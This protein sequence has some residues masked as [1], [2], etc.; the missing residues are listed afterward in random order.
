MSSHHIVR[1]KQE[2]ALFIRNLGHFDE[3]YLGQ[4]LEWSPTL[5]VS[6]GVYEKVVSLGLKV[7]VVAGP[8]DP[9]HFQENT[10][11]VSGRADELG[12][13]LEDAVSKGY[14]AINIIDLQNSYLGALETY[15]KKINIVV[16]TPQEKAYAVRSGFRV[17]KPAG[18][19]FRFSGSSGIEADNLVLQNRSDFV[20]EKDG[21]VTFRFIDDYLI[22]RESL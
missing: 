22:I 5:I 12:A 15:L 11:T 3:E 2:P 14:T 16:Y 6:A 19:V 17:W 8:G 21:F 10:R 13:V 20:V 7:D 1:E 4:L 9:V 18:S